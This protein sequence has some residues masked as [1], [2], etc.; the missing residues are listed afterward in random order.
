MTTP[1][2]SQCKKIERVSRIVSFLALWGAG[3]ATLLTLLSLTLTLA[4][5]TGM[6]ESWTQA[7]QL[8][9]QEAHLDFNQMSHLQ[10]LSL[11]GSMSL[12][13]VL[14]S[15]SFYCLFRLFQAFKKFGV[16]SSKAIKFARALAWTFSCTFIYLFVFDLFAPLATE[17]EAMKA[18]ASNAYFQDAILLGIIWVGVWIL[19]YGHDLLT[20]NEMTI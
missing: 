14:V 6:P 2:I 11:L 16:F 18:Y 5:L 7:I 8:Y 19:E 13:L 17:S 1:S 20:E 9:L 4:Q 3:L 10:K 12:V 15:A